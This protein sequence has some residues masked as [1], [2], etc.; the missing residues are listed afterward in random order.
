MRVLPKLL[1][2]LAVAACAV[3]PDVPRPVPVFFTDNSAELGPEGRSAV[4]TA[5]DLMRSAPTSRATLV[6]YTSTDISGPDQ[7][8][9]ATSRAQAVRAE[10]VRDGI[11]A[12]RIQ[13]HAG[14][15][16]PPPAGTPVQSRRVDITFTR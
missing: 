14:G 11:P 4:Q 6:G 10:L 5:A 8:R 16:L 3:L 7:K 15:P 12:T 1:P 2:L 13:D 9:L